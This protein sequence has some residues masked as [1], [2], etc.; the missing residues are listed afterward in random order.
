MST[1]DE[2]LSV[3]DGVIVANIFPLAS[4]MAALMVITTSREWYALLKADEYTFSIDVGDR[5]GSAG[6]TASWDDT[7]ST[8]LDY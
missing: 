5:A 1:V 2:T 8:R 7:Q 4:F 6:S 3:Y